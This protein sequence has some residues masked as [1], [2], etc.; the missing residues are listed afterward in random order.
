M[1]APQPAAHGREVKKARAVS[2]ALLPLLLSNP[3]FIPA[4]LKSDE[5]NQRHQ[6]VSIKYVA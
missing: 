3:P 1:E 6:V 5:L 4:S 2:L